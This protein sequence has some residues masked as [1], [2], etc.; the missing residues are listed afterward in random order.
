MKSCQIMIPSSSQR[1]RTRPS[2]NSRRPSAE[3]CS[4]SRFRRLQDL[5]VL[6]GRDAVWKTV[7]RNDIRPF[8]KD[9]NAVH[10][11]L[12]GAPPLVKIAT[13][14][15]RAESSVDRLIILHAAAGFQLRVKG[16]QGP[17][18]RTR[19]DTTDRDV[20]MSMGRSMWLTPEFS[21]TSRDVLPFLPPY[22]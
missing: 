10:D 17:G 11:E 21:S 8:G 7:E 16:V 9:R 5:P 6:R 20:R 1:H 22:S 14:N 2:R 12:E 13:Q 3:S 18:G 15:N 19:S 4:C